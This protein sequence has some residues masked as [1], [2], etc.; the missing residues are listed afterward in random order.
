M[1]FQAR[2][3]TQIQSLRCFAD[4]HGYELKIPTGSEYNACRGYKD[5]FFKKHCTVAEWLET[6]HKN[7]VAAIVDADVV[8]AV[9][10]RGLEK[11]ANHPADVQVYQRCLLPEIMAGNYMV[12]NTA[13]ARTFLRNW[14]KYNFEMPR[15][16]SSSDNGAIHLVVQDTVQAI[17]FPKCKKLYKGL[18]KPV[19][20]LKDYFSFVKCTTDALGPPRDWHTSGGVV[21]V[22]PRFNFWAADGVYMNK[23]G[24]REFGPVLHHGIKDAKDVTGHYFMNVSECRPHTANVMKTAAEVGSHMLGMARSYQEYFP[25]GRNCPGTAATQCPERCLSTFSCWPLGDREPPLP[26][27]TC[28][29]CG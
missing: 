9:F 21:T 23:M 18:N 10:D 8:S 27:R 25:Q 13:F 17:D 22:W 5:Y 29:D 28:T 19:T 26:R 12:R 6:Q 4:K 1:R 2:Y 3:Q 16:F 7:L 24:S 11:W 15:G 20:D 14:A